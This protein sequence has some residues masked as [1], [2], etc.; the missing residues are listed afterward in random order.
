MIYLISNCRTP[1]IHYQLEGTILLKIADPQSEVFVMWSGVLLYSN[2]FLHFILNESKELLN[3]S[4][5]ILPFR[6]ENL[7]FK[8]FKPIF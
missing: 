1:S 7:F 4:S 2:S 8:I 5:G 6:T 3:Q